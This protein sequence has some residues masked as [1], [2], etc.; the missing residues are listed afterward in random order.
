[1]NIL[2]ADDDRIQIMLVTAFLRK[3]GFTVSSAFDAMQAFTLAIRTTPAAIVLD[4]NMPGGT[5]L[6]VLK[7]LKNSYNTNQIPVIV[8][9]GSIDQET[10]AKVKELGADEYLPKPVDLE[11]LRRIIHRVIGTPVDLQLGT[12]K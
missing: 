9:S 10:S 2:I 1:M 7:R 8:V 4:V 11:A 3:A 5:G 12:Q 6:E